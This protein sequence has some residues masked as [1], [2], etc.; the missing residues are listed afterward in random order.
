LQALNRF[1]SFNQGTT[2]G[3]INFIER[4]ES[5]VMEYAV[6]KTGGK[7]YKVSPGD[8]ILVDRLSQDESQNEVVFENVLLVNTDGKIKLGTPMVEA[9]VTGELVRH[10][11][12]DK[13]RVSRFKA[14]SN[15]RRVVGFRHSL[16]EVKITN[17]NSST[18]KKE[19]TEKKD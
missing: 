14:K 10:F 9:T 18:G 3:G 6:V 16:S 4:F 13:I 12:G 17:I 19:G 7:Q 8:V 15:F 5:K 11:K 1:L 2:L